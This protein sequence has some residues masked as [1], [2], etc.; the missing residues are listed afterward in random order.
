MFRETFFISIINCLKTF[1]DTIKVYEVG[2]RYVTLFGH[3]NVR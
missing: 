2:R 1:I 3:Y